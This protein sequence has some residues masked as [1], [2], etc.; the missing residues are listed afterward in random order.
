MK[1]ITMAVITIF[2]FLYSSTCSSPTPV[3]KKQGRNE[4]ILVLP[5][6]NAVHF[7]KEHEYAKVSGAQLELHLISNLRARGWR[8]ISTGNK[9][10]TH[11]DIPTDEAIIV[12]GKKLSADYALYVQ[13]GEFM[14]AL[15]PWGDHQDWIELKEARLIDIR[16]EKIVWNI[17]KSMKYGGYSINCGNMT[18]FLPAMAS[19]IA[20]GIDRF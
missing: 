18:S 12:E 15:F 5:P 9:K 11:H 1:T 8:V 6:K 3:I 20:D 13:L 10:F 16:S 17:D 4:T 14:D 7:G 19:N 2:V